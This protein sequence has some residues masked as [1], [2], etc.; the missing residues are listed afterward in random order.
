MKV[1]VGQRGSGTTTDLLLEASKFKDNALFISMYGADYIE[2]KC[3]ALEID[4]PIVVSWQD[5]IDSNFDQTKNYRIFI[6]NADALIAYLCRQ[7][8]IKGRLETVSFSMDR[9]EKRAKFLD[10][11]MIEPGQAIKFSDNTFGKVINKNFE[12]FQYECCNGD[13]GT[14]WRGENYYENGLRWVG[15]QE[16]ES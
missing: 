16:I 3:K 9:M 6:D 2:T 8:N 10:W 4:P 14:I 1:L 12:L 15:C 11:D 5:V 7:Y 13:T